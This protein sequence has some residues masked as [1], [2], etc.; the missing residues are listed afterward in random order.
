M[1]MSQAASSE[2]DLWDPRT[3]LAGLSSVAKFLVSD[4]QG[5]TILAFALL[6][7]VA[8]VAFVPGVWERVSASAKGFAVS[9]I[10]RAPAWTAVGSIAGI[11]SLVVAIATLIIT[12]RP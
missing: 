9:P 12:T 6:G 8:Y 5:R 3:Y 4:P 7:V 11:L 1:A 10:W 2:F